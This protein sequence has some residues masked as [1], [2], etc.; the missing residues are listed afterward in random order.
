MSGQP[1]STPLD[2]L[3]ADVVA[4]LDEA[5]REAFEERAGIIEFDA[6]LPRAHAEC[7]ALI[8]VLLHRAN[9]AGLVAL[10]VEREGRRQWLLATDPAL[11]RRVAGRLGAAEIAVVDPL[12]VLRARCGGVAMLVPAGA[13]PPDFGPP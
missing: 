12:E 1:C 2:P 6:G 4:R 13:S 10:E 9:P 8:G 5:Q 11:A 3:V 7:L